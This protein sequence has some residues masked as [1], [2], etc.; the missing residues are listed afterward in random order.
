MC[1]LLP[2][3]QLTN[4]F[5]SSIGGASLPT[6]S[7][8]PSSKCVDQ[9]PCKA[10]GQFTHSKA[11]R[12]ASVFSLRAK[13]TWHHTKVHTLSWKCASEIGSAAKETKLGN[14]GSEIWI[15]H[16]WSSPRNSWSW[17]GC[18]GGPGLETPEKPPEHPG[19]QPDEGRPTGT[20][21]QWL[22]QKGWRCPCKWHWHKISW[23]SSS[24]SYFMSL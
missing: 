5:R 24:Q 1:T 3:L 15:Q 9:R 8:V 2:T 10:G 22:W 6:A 16:K 21:G 23:K 14:P 7:C 17:E 11:G 20:N 18:L 4:R 13:T 12:C 19:V